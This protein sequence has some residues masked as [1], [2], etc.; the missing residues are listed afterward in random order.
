M[1][2]PAACD[3]CVQPRDVTTPEGEDLTQETFRGPKLLI[4][5]VDVRKASTK[6]IE[7]IRTLTEDLEGNVD[8]LILTSSPAELMEA[9]RHDYQLAVPFAFADATV[10]KTILRSNPGIALWKDGVVLGN[11]HYN[12][13]P[14]SSEVT[15]LIGQP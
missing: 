15:R 11:W 9:F 13:T 6:N 1:S 7:A 10:L 14:S 12:D 3:A 4:I 8:A 5:M 2:E